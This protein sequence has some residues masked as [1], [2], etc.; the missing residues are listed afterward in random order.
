MRT[1]LYES[2]KSATG[3]DYHDS[4]YIDAAQ[5]WADYTPY[6]NVLWLWFLLDWLK[7]R[8]LMAESLSTAHPKDVRKF[9]KDIE[10][11]MA[12]LSPEDKSAPDFEDAAGV[13]E[14]ALERGW[15]AI[16]DLMDEGNS[17]LD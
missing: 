4:E 1:W 6:T 12:H 11:L 15:V 7:N 16:E 5:S 13:A 14:F 17:V 3:P 8:M 9:C 10:E 2:S